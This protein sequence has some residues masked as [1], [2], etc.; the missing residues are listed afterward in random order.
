MQ[1]EEGKHFLFWLLFLFICIKYNCG[2]KL[3]KDI[4][5]WNVW[6]I[7][8]QHVTP[9]KWD[10]LK[11]IIRVY[12]ILFTLITCKLDLLACKWDL[13]TC[14]SL[15]LACTLDLCL[16]IPKRWRCRSL[17]WEISWNRQ[18]YILFHILGNITLMLYC[19]ISI[20][21]RT[22]YIMSWR[23]TMQYQ[24]RKVLS[25]LWLQKMTIPAWA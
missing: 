18:V 6:Q 10:L 12:S 17:R 24:W 4:K 5:Q 2:K 13:L 19:R 9:D 16:P 25:P 8:W 11:T 3:W 15:L 14:K 7:W 23:L 21:M 1:S 22:N 20:K